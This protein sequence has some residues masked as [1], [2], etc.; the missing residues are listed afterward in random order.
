MNI[1][2]DTNV[3]LVAISRKSVYR[4]IFD[5]FLQERFTLCVTTDILIEY[6]EII[7]YH[8]G[9]DIA[10]NLLQLIE[11]ANNVEHTFRFF[12]WG[13]IKADM[14]DNNFVDCAIASNATFLVSNDY[15]FNILK[16]I[17]FPKVELLQADDF[18]EYLRLNL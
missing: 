2:I 6:E 11:N 14:D 18:L 13:L 10:S 7:G 17:P 15:H 16:Q 1:V 12:K 5:A 4:P 3:L 8:L 9:R